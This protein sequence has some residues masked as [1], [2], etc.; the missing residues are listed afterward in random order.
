MT[1]SYATNLSVFMTSALM[2]GAFAATL[3]SLWALRGIM[4]G[5]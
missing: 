2:S 1:N 4:L 3:A 5:A